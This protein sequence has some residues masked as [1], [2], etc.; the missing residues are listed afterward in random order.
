[1][2]RVDEPLR[3]DSQKVLAVVA[4]P[5]AVVALQQTLATTRLVTTAVVDWLTKTLGAVAAVA[6]GQLVAM[7]DKV[8][9]VTY[10]T[11]LETVGLALA[12]RTVLLAGVVVLGVASILS[13]T[14]KM[15]S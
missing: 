10:I 14:Q 13:H 3:T 12:G 7:P 15:P 2:A 1:V 5:Q 8:A 4:A 9:T 11:A 6:L